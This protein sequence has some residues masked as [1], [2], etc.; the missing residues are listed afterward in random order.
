MA[1]HV[2]EVF[3]ASDADS[4]GSLNLDEFRTA[5]NGIKEAVRPPRRE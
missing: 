5:L 2:A 3:K 4:N 1:A